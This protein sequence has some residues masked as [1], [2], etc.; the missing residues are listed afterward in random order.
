[1]GKI[2]IRDLALR[3]IVGAFPE[4]RCDKQD[5]LINA[6]VTGDFLSATGSDSLADAIDYKQITKRIIAL[7]EDSEFHLIETLADHIAEI[8]VEHPMVREARVTVDKPG[9][10]RFAR[11]VA[12][13]VTRRR[14]Q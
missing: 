14:D 10:L 11:S 1:M 2:F 3:C 5:I 12:V 8:C 4:E 9:A 13:E 7:V 6:A